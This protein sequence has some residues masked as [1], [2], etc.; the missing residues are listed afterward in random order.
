ML[1]DMARTGA[2]GKIYEF[3]TTVEVQNYEGELVHLAALAE[4][5]LAHLIADEGVATVRQYFAR[6][7]A[8]RLQIG[9]R[10]QGISGDNVESTAV[11]L[12]KGAVAAALKDDGHESTRSRVASTLL[13]GV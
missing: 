1:R 13:A 9:L 7:L 4:G 6:A 8:D 12:A 2:S 3:I 11:D 10:F 5:E